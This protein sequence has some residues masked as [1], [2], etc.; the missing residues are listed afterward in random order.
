[1]EVNNGEIKEPLI[2]DVGEEKPYTEAEKKTALTSMLHRYKQHLRDLEIDT[3]HVKT[4]AGR[5]ALIN[6]ISITIDKLR[7][8][9]A[10]L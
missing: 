8:F 4:K 9:E 10:E 1:M 2:S 6:E 7:A 5:E 3:L